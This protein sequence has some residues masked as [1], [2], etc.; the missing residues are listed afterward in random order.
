V[1][2]SGV[3]A[4]SAWQKRPDVIGKASG[5]VDQPLC[6]AK[7]IN[8]RQCLDRS[9]VVSLEKLNLLSVKLDELAFN[10]P[11]VLDRFRG[12]QLASNS[13]MVFQ[14]PLDAV[15]VR[16]DE[17]VHSAQYGSA[18]IKQMPFDLG[19]VVDVNSYPNKHW[20]WNRGQQPG[21]AAVTKNGN[22]YRVTG[23]I[24][25]ASGS[26]DASPVPF[27]FEATCP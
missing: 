22:T 12:K 25:P 13:Q 10:G 18:L 16:I 27:A 24:A 11:A 7:I 14:I 2:D 21:D 20:A 1:K 3:S 15:A 26:A 9:H 8:R 4:E 5:V 6:W 23:S 17:P 19:D